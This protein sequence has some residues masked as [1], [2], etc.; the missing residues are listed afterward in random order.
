MGNSEYR[1]Q[2]IKITIPYSNLEIP[3][4]LWFEER[5]RLRITVKLDKTIIAK[6]PLGYSITEVREKLEK[7]APWIVQQ[8]E[9]FDQY[10][11]LT[12]E[13][14]YI[15]GE[16]YYYLGRQYRLKVLSGKNN[17]VKLVGKYFFLT[18][19]QIDNL[20]KK[21]QLMQGWYSDHAKALINNRLNHQIERIT[22]I[23]DK[24]PNVKFRKM[25]K[26]WGSCTPSGIITFN[27]DLI[28][29]PSHCIDYVILHEIIHLI[30]GGHNQKFYRMLETLMPDWRKRKERLERI[31]IL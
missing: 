4:T 7:R 31:N 16:T 18:T 9:F 24:K 1:E 8:L 3:I 10:H 12:P 23:K 2:P 21:Q 20:S 15:S 22:F 13:R 28:K 27:T 17:H 19:S 25:N 6:A 14:Q 29:A 5:E 30:H 26:R 11:P